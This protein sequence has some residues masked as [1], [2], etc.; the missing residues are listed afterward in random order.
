MVGRA[1]LP[2]SP[3]QLRF[4]TLEKPKAQAFPI[5]K[6]PPVGAPPIIFSCILPHQSH[7]TPPHCR[8]PYRPYLT[9][10][11]NSRLTSSPDFFPHSC[12][13]NPKLYLSASGPCAFCPCALSVRSLSAPFLSLTLSFVLTHFAS[14]SGPDPFCLGLPGSPASAWPATT[15]PIIYPSH[16]VRDP[17]LISLIPSNSWGLVRRRCRITSRVSNTSNSLLFLSGS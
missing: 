10:T 5:G 13:A 8:L 17:F 6:F 14:N 15:Y 11:F 16:D 3:S 7:R 1:S 4:P 2:N 9:N 12:P